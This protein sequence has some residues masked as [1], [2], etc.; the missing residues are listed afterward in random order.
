MTS[1][2]NSFFYHS[3]VPEDNFIKVWITFDKLRNCFVNELFSMK[4]SNPGCILDSK[5]H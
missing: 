4:L 3:I 1:E 5:K 2:T